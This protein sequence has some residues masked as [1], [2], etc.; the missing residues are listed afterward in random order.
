MTGFVKNQTLEESMPWTSGGILRIFWSGLAT[1]VG[2]VVVS[3]IA[4]ELVPHA[5]GISFFSELRYAVLAPVSI[6]ITIAAAFL[7]ASLSGRIER[8][9]SIFAIILLVLFLFIFLGLELLGVAGLGA[10]AIPA[11]FLVLLTIVLLVP[12]L[13]DH[14]I[15]SPIGIAAVLIIGVLEIVGIATALS[16]ERAKPKNIRDLA[17]EIPRTIFDVDHK[18][19]DLS[20]GARIH[21]VDEGN[22]ETLLFLHGNPSWSFQW[23]TLIQG[24]RGSYRCIALDY[25]GFGLSTAPPEFGFTPLEQSLIIEE[26]VDR[27][28]IR[29]VTLVMQDWGGPFGLGFAERRPKLIRNVILGSTWAWKTDTSTSRGRFSVIAGGPVGEFVQMNFNGFTSLAIKNGV[30]RELS[31]A[32]IDA[33][34]SPYRPLNRRGI[35][36]FYPGQIV[37]ATDY[38][39]K[40]E[41]ELPRLADKKALIFWALQDRGFPRE[42][43]I[44]FQKAFPRHKTIELPNANHFFFEDSAELMIEEMRTFLSRERKR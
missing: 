7:Y 34:L 4:V 2:T 42:D 23:R 38:F 25:P 16:S 14:P 17:M 44:K 9:R 15:R 19:M 6:L 5:R 3:T 20:S 13:V 43:L 36:A 30:V 11:L 12:R 33:Y 26:F 18:F 1:S 39:T 27:L 22:G 35:A 31:P 40:I 21:Y 37:A 29:N 41:T 8:A 24:L 10:A 32:V 28:G